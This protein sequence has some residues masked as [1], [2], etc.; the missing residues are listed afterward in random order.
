M[1][2]F[3]PLAKFYVILFAAL[4]I[5][6]CGESDSDS[7]GDYETLCKI[8]Q[9]FTNDSELSPLDTALA[10]DTAIKNELPEIYISYEHLSQLP[11]AEVYPNLQSLAKQQSGKDWECS[12]M[13]TYY[14]P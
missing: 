7:L 6:S 9:K 12:A 2:V 1:N 14:Q 13:E 3:K 11:P 4:I 8:Y 10:I 5:V